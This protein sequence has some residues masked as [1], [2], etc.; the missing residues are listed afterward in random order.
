VDKEANN[1]LKLAFRFFTHEEVT[2]M[3]EPPSIFIGPLEEK[4]IMNEK[5]FYDFQ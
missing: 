1:L 5:Q 4:R 2:I 3:L